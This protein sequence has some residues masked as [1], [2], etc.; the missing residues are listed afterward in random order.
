MAPS[1][2]TA[3]FVCFND[4]ISKADWSPGFLVHK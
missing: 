4:Y 2:Q 3:M 1:I